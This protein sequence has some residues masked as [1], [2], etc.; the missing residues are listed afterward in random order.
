[1]D[2]KPATINEVKAIVRE[3]LG[4]CSA[5]QAEVFRRF[6]VEPYR[7]PL[8]RY[9][10]LEAVVIVA[11]NCL[12]V[13]YWEDVEEGFNVSRISS[14][15]E[16]LDHFCN[17]DDLGLALERWLGKSSTPPMPMMKPSS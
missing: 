4:K 10:K 12:E 8:L 11:R 2:W 16:I 17:Q 14:Q 6:A 1:M 13:M 9:G 3:D 5:A 7:A 15:G